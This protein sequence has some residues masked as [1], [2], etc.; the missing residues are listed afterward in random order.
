MILKLILKDIRAHSS[1]TFI[2]IL[3]PMAILN[4]FFSL[5][6][7]PV[8]GFIIA[9]FMVIAVACSMFSFFEKN[10]RTE[11]L[12]RSLP[13]TIQAVVL[14]RYLTSLVISL[15]GMIFYYIGAFIVS[16]LYTNPKASFN[17][18]N[19]LKVLFIAAFCVV[20]Y[21]AIFIPAMLK[22]RFFGS[23]LSS[24]LALFATI[25]TTVFLFQPYKLAF[26]PYFEPGD[27]ILVIFL[28]IFLIFASIVSV[29]ISLSIYKRKE[30]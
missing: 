30:F 29:A 13:V 28:T 15:G 10:K 8:G 3:F 7:Y 9:G 20:L 12:T 4:S 6:F 27:L 26:K 19:N 22:F 23:I 5:R 18:I 16:F 25:L 21:N 14:A 11:I 17:D 1:L 24:V 2:Y